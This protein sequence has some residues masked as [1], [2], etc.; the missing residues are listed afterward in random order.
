ML[1]RLAVL[2]DILD[3]HASVLGRDFHPYRNHTYRVANFHWCLLPGSLEDLYV[4]SVAVAFHDLGIWTAGTF[5]YLA[6][7]E[8]LARDYLVEQQRP[9]LVTVVLAMIREHH[10]ISALPRGQ[11]PR[12]ETFR[13]ADWIDVSMGT[14]RFD[15]STDDFRRTVQRFPRLGFHL[16]LLQFSLRHG[17]R[18]PLRPLP[19]LK[20]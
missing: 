5:D 20:R 4:L 8:A 3:A 14:L 15:L 12:I 11:D 18:H 7:S 9:E 16:R 13:R 6:P 1:D 10:R 19:M 17:L 2:D